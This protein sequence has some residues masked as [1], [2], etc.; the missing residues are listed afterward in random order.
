MKLV[1]FLGGHIPF[2]PC[3][4]G[5]GTFDGFHLGHREL[6]RR[7]VSRARELQL[8][9]VLFTFDLPPKKILDPQNFPG[10]LTLP[11]EKFQLLLESGVDWVV[12]RTFDKQFAVTYSQEFVR[13]ILAEKL[14]AREVFVGFNFGFG[15]NREGTADSLA[16]DLHELGIGC[17]I[18]PRV[19]IDGVTISSTF[20][21]EQIKSGNLDQATK[22]L[23]RPVT[24]TGTVIHGEKRG[25]QMGFPTAN[26][27]LEHPVKVLPPHGVYD[28]I[29]DTPFG[30]YQAMTNI[31]V[32]PT[33]ARHTP[34]LEAHLLGFNGDLYSQTIR[35]RF[36]RRLREERCFPSMESL[37]AQ[38]KCDL[39][40]VRTSSMTRRGHPRDM[41]QSS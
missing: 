29:A 25:R 2:G 4:L 24:L 32:R 15:F 33:F 27:S 26:L 3:V 7:M 16:T 23:G 39:E 14:Q 41:G 18:L 12:F 10:A 19:S 36:Y 9:A 5:L 30:S 11:E 6:V 17:Q 22:W 35:V 37:I 34:L 21:R 38:M 28:T 1:N 13:R 40:E 20:I 31:G 8:P